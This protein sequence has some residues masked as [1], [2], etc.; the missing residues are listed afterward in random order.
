MKIKKIATL[1]LTTLMGMSFMVACQETPDTGELQGDVKV[2]LWSAPTTQKIM[3]DREYPEYNDCVLS[4][5]MAKNEIEGAQVIITPTDDYKVKSFD[6][7]TSDLKNSN[8]DVI[9]KDDVKV[10]LQKYVRIDKQINGNNAYGAGYQPDPI[11]PFDVAKE[12]GENTVVGKNQG[13]YVTVETEADTVSG[14]YSGNL[15]VSIDG[16]NYNVPMSVNVWNFAISDAVHSRSAFSIWGS[17][18]MNNEMDYT[19]EKMETYSDALLQ[20]RLSPLDLIFD[21]RGTA[22]E[23]LD[24]FIEQAKKAT[25]DER[26][27]AFRLH[28][29]FGEG[30][31][32]TATQLRTNS[33]VKMVKASTE[34]CCLL[35]KMIFYFG[36]TID[37]PQYTNTGHLVN[38]CVESVRKSAEDTIK[39]LETDGW[40]GTVSAEFGE[41]VKEKLRSTPMILTGPYETYYVQDGGITYC[42]LFDQFST[43]EQRAIYANEK[44]KNGEVW[45]YGCTGPCFPWP[46]YHIDDHLLGARVLNWMMYDYDIDGNL[47]WCVNF[48]TVDG[49][50]EDP[51]DSVNYKTMNG[52]G[53]LFYPGVDYGL[54]VPVST[55]R[56]ETIRDGL[57]D[58]EYFYELEQLT[59][60]LSEYYGE[61]VSAKS[62]LQP[63]FKRLYTNVFYN[64][65]SANFF[66]VRKEIADIM[67]RCMGEEKFVLKDV[68]YSGENATI[69]F[70]VA[71]GYSVK[72]NGESVNGTAQGQGLTFTKTIKLDKQINLFEIVVEKDGVSKTIT[73]DAGA[74]TVIAADFANGANTSVVIGNGNNITVSGALASE[75]A[76]ADDAAKVEIVSTFD[77]AN[78][79]LSLTYMPE[80]AISL[81]ALDLTPAGLSTVRIRLYNASGQKIRIRYLLKSTSGEYEFVNKVLDEGW[82]TLS[83]EGIEKSGWSQA[84][85]VSKIVLRFENTVDGKNQEAMPKQTV[86][87]GEVLV[88][89]AN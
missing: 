72:I 13:I 7:K 66:N 22:D 50:L 84:G 27:T 33:L 46:T 16:K 65:D 78:P 31:T 44:E 2:K 69:S 11:L 9:S 76:G 19:L 64:T 40:F 48:W 12:Y 4:Y 59:T 41:H 55:L 39:Q 83:I 3:R 79:L 89:Y 75:W 74:K 10:Y 63:L 14:V 34:D 37:E 60:G 17:F 26:V 53:Y 20:N 1:G 62:M 71:N 77:P 70:N 25:M 73:V 47:Y 57:E 28:P 15:T 8:G 51:Y 81:S 5:D 85:S 86:Y 45:W 61:A 67:E 6:V 82:N 68:S 36:S 54:D 21:E 88:G 52:D 56:M 35:D 43:E 32:D 30:Y 42:P 29:A 24:S 58:Y 23:T 38:P 87:I 18:M 80:I 49:R